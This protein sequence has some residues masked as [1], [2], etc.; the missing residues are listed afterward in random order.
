MVQSMKIEQHFSYDYYIKVYY[1]E[2]SI[3]VY[4]F[5]SSD[6]IIHRDLKLQKITS[7]TDE[8]SAGCRIWVRIDQFSVD[9]ADKP[10]NMLT[11]PPPQSLL[12]LLLQC[13]KMNLEPQIVH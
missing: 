1:F 9:P 2:L 13:E 11:H 3:I 4:L 12:G 5:T 6:K 10:K 7:L 8:L